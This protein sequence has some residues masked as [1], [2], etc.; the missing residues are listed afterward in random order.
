MLQHHRIHRTQVI[1][2]FLHCHF[3]AREE[4]HMLMNLFGMPEGHNGSYH[5]ETNA[6][7]HLVFS[8]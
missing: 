4:V 8:S 5:S 2:V 6:S 1:T 7:Y 3:S